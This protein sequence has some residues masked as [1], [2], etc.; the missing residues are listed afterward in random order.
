[1]GKRKKASGAHAALIEDLVAANHILY[2][3][4]VVDGFGHISAR[5]DRDP[6]RFLLA[7]SCAPSLVEADDILTYDLDGNALDAE[8]EKLYAE[9]FIHA[10]IFAA[11]ADVNAVV[12]SHSP[13][14]IPFG[15]TDVDLRPVYH[16][17][18]F[19]GEGVKRFDTRP[20][21]GDTN[22]LVDDMRLGQAL[23]LALAD[24][25]VCLM[26][27]HGSV[28]VG[29]HVRQAVYRAIYTEMNARLQSEAMRLSG[30]VNYLNDGESQRTAGLNELFMDRPW[31]LWTEEAERKRG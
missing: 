27:G 10:A 6:K 30:N 21:A 9:R 14:I 11:R 8:G 20:I 31:G 5:D 3:Q 17:S 7:R 1:M 12:H 22:L 19:L 24:K 28:A 13:A 25:S 16:M 26:R 4:G 15:I 29:S 2:D 23:A 18:G